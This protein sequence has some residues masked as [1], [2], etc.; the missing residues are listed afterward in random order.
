VIFDNDDMQVLKRLLRMELMLRRR[1]FDRLQNKYSEKDFPTSATY[2]DYLR[3]NKPWLELTEQDLNAHHEKYFTQFVGN[4]EVT[5]MEGL[6]QNLEKVAPS[7]GRAR[8]AHNTWA[9]IKAIGYEQTR[10]SMADQTFRT[11]RS[12]LL[13]AGLTA[14]DLQQNN[15]VAFR[16]RTIVISSPVCNWSDLLRAA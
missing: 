4:V 2:L 14:A 1:W 6:L 7:V 11:H 10:A 9:L 16:K 15:V 3:N 5:D 13:R 12:W 8:A